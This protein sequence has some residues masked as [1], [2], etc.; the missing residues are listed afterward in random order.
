ML[1]FS[2]VSED[3]AIWAMD[4]LDKPERARP[5]RLI[6]STGRDA[7]PQLSPD[8]HTLVFASN[9]L[10]T[11]EIW[12]SDADGRN[13]MRLTHFNRNPGAGSP[14]WSPDGNEIAFDCRISDNTDIYIMTRDGRQLQRLTDSPAENAVPTWSRDGQWIYFT[15][16]RDGEHQIWK[17]PVSGGPPQ[18]VTR[19]GGFIGF[20]GPDGFFYYVKSRD[21][22]C[23][24]WRRRMS[25]NVETP[26][27]TSHRPVL[28]DFWSLN[29]HGVY[30]VDAAGPNGELISIL[31][32]QSFAG[33][34]RSVAHM[35]SLRR[36]GYPGL[37]VSAMGER[38]LY[39]QVDRRAAEIK[40]M[41]PFE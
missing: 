23:C 1:A 37:S 39:S 17:L 26:F 3:S 6:A 40:I 2:Q 29:A 20:E 7:S 14:R 34:P 25:D 36:I 33:L 41:K 4:D 12:I 30:F 8:G 5:Y 31:R 11:L 32:Y 9:R 28:W 13:P 10:G 22:D 19:T 38:V 27:I 16:N 21:H 35:D 24:I 15:S 18:R